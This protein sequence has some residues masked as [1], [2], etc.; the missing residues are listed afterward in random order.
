MKHEQGH[1]DIVYIYAVKL[2]QIFEQTSFYKSNY[3]T[4]TDGIFKVVFAKKRAEQARYDLETNHSKN[5]VE[6]KKW[7]DYF[8]DTINSFSTAR[9]EKKP[10]FLVS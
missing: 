5:R 10:Q 4:E 1:A 2:K 9:L 8:E 3:K 6:Q 7:N